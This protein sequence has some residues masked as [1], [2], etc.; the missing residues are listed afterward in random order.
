M[1]IV[2]IAKIF[3]EAIAPFETFFSKPQT[4][5]F[6]RLIFGLILCLESRNISDI[7]EKTLRGK[8]QSSLN[9]FLTESPW[10]QA[11]L[12]ACRRNV[13]QDRINSLKPSQL[14]VIIDDTLSR[15]YGKKMEGV[16]WHYSDTDRQVTLGHNLISSTVIAVCDKKICYQI[17]LDSALYQKKKDC[18]K[19]N[20]FQSKIAL[21]TQ[22]LEKF[23]VPVS[24]R[25]ILLMDTWYASA[26]LLSIAVKHGF[27]YIVPIKSNRVV[28]LNRGKTSLTRLAKQEAGWLKVKVKKETF[29]VK[30]F[31]VFIKGLGMV[32]LVISKKKR[33][34]KSFKAFIT[35]LDWSASKI[36]KAYSYR[37]VIETF[38]EDAKIH[39]GLDQY[40]IR[41]AR[42]IEKYWEIVF[43]AYQFL[44][45]ANLQLHWK[46]RL[47]TTG[48]KCLWVRKL[49][50]QSLLDWIFEQRHILTQSQWNKLQAQLCL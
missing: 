45:E 37:W 1:P 15:K 12:H 31:E 17:P 26:Q 22:F 6:H 44:E 40:Q 13:L 2:K 7:N 21:A 23:E 11:D 19:P 49:F 29:W 39:L 10:K 9:R 16:G 20:G 28:F 32:K 33:Y 5:N 35:N 46:K 43:T 8:D 30:T 25:S 36:L 24:T 14:Y 18:E 48:Q 47:R 4:Q 42:A 3:L 34:G 27:D 41:K 50:T 38:Y